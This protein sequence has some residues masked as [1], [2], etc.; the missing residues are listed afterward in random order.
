MKFPEQDFK[1]FEA[2]AFLIL[3][4]S[5]EGV[6]QQELL[7]SP[8]SYDGNEVSFIL[9]IKKYCEKSMFGRIKKLVEFS[10]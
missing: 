4:F 8:Y 7:S 9:R 2:R 3:R 6:T 5:F 10:K 1:D